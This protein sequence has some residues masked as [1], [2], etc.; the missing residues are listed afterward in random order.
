[1]V[2]AIRLYTL[3]IAHLFGSYLAWNRPIASGI[4]RCFAV[5]QE[6][7]TASL[8][9]RRPMTDSS[10]ARCFAVHQAP[11]DGL[12]FFHALS[13]QSSNIAALKD[14]SCETSGGFYYIFK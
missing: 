6:S 3:M 12:C 9:T 11:A 1:M 14:T 8:C 7:P 4:S 13:L 5:P 2:R 10:E